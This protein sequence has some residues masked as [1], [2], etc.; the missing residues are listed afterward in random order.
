M[1]EPEAQTPI[2]EEI[3]AEIKVDLDAPNAETRL[4]ALQRLSELAYSTQTILRTL[5]QM[6]LNDRSKAVRKDALDFSGKTG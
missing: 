4:S 6:A 5:E 1:T 2:P 3:L